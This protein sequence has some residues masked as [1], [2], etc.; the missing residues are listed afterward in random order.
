[1]MMI[2]ITCDC[3]YFVAR[4]FA[5]LWDIMTLN[6]QDMSIESNILSIMSYIVWHILSFSRLLLAQA[7]CS[8][9]CAFEDLFPFIY[10]W[11]PP[12]HDY[13]IIW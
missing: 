12:I 4:C 10:T 3:Q 1:M 11:Q 5:M 8:N 2:V 13:M 6:D 9:S 7:V